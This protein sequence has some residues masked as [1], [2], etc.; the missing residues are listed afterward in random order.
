[1]SKNALVSHTK[2]GINRIRTATAV[3]V[4]PHDSIP[5]LIS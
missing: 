1:L 5:S 3:I 4:A 2:K